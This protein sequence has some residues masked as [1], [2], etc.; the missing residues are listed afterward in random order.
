[1]PLLKARVDISMDFPRI[2]REVNELAKRAVAEAAE[3]G[4]R[5]TS[6]AAARRSKTGRMAGTIVEPVRGSP[7]GWI[8]SFVSPGIESWFQ[9]YGTLGN[10]RKPLK[11][12]ARGNRTRA[13]GTGIEPLRHLD[14]GRAAGTAA[15]RRVIS[16]GI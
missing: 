3:Q 14:I 7:D 10:R 12:A 8:A 9:N 15:L 16:G 1:M 2:T 11:Q 13:P 6:A 5:A 4:A